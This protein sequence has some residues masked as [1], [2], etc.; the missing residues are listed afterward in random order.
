MLFQRKDREAGRVSC[1][2]WTEVSRGSE[3]LV[4]VSPTV[5]RARVLKDPP[6]KKAGWW[7]GCWRS[8]DVLKSRQRDQLASRRRERG[9]TTSNSS[10]AAT[11]NNKSPTNHETRIYHSTEVTQAGI[12]NL[13]KNN[14]RPVQS[15]LQGIQCQTETKILIIYSQGSVKTE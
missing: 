12:V 9:R 3:R 11:T 7:G 14:R 8:A 15:K 10:T 1:V 2:A 13:N 5:I 4:G 6:R